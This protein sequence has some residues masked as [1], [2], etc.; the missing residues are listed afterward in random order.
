MEMEN[1][2]DCSLEVGAGRVGVT[3]GLGFEP[4]E[5]HMHEES[6]SCAKASTAAVAAFYT[7]PDTN[8]FLRLLQFL[9]L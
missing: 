8:V 1:V 2:L 9:L 3:Y 5:K 6:R 7:H 4:H